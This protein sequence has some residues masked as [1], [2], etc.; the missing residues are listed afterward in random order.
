MIPVETRHIERK[1]LRPGDIIIERSGGGPNQPVGRV[2]MFEGDG[3]FCF[4]NFTSR[5]RVED[6][7]RVEPDYLLFW[8]LNF[9]LSGQTERLQRRTTGIRNLAFNDYKQTHL[10]LPPV[11]RQRD[12]TAALRGVEAVE[13]A[14]T[15]EA[16]LHDELFAALLDE[17]MTG[18]LSAAPLIP[19]DDGAAPRDR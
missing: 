3:T 13:L 7:E 9:H 5:L 14:L 11:D 10:P 12:I 1:R 15:R 18:R 17:L 19:T 16:D 6:R 4:S 8:L 2:V